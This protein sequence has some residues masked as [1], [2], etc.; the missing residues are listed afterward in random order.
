MPTPRLMLSDVAEDEMIR[1]DRAKGEGEEQQDG[2]LHE[3]GGVSDEE[4]LREFDEVL[5]RPVG[6]RVPRAAC[7]RLNYPIYNFTCGLCAGM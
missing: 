4:L 2:D 7:G 1:H 5:R 6:F 3:A